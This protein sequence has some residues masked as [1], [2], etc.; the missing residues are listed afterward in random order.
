MYGQCSGDLERECECGTKDYIPVCGEVDDGKFVTFFSP[1]H[2]G[3][4]IHTKQ[5]DEDSMVRNNEHDNYELVACNCVGMFSSKIVASQLFEPKFP[6]NNQDLEKTKL[7]TCATYNCDWRIYFIVPC[8][9]LA[10]FLTFFEAVPV[11]TGCQALVT[12][13]LG[14]AGLG[15]QALIFRCFGSIPIPLLRVLGSRDSRISWT[16]IS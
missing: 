6:E 12:E 13:H 4:Y 16:S 7:G 10:C 15:L 9:A 5:Q 14:T 1:C 11:T 3:C 8:L 2:A